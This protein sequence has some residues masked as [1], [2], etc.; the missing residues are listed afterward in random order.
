VDT[1]LAAHLANIT[2]QKLMSEK[3]PF[4]M[5]L[6]S[7]V[8]AELDK[9]CRWSIGRYTFSHFR[10]KDGAEVDIVVE[11]QAGRVAGIEIKA[12]ATVGRKDF[13]GL[14]RLRLAAGNRFA[15]GVVL[16]DGEDSLAF[17]DG[18]RAVP[19]STLWSPSSKQD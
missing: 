7:F 18:R 14:A 13:T 12:S 19:I 9:Q 15:N 16:Y 10:D 8:L 17:G 11:D 4:G 5:L 2:E 6:E 3:G 1:G